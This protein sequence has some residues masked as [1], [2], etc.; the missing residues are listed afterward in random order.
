MKVLYFLEPEIERGNPLFRFGTVRNHL[1]FEIP[2][3]AAHPDVD[4][5]LVCS[6]AVHK[7]IVDAGFLA[8]M[9]I[10]G[11]SEAEVREIHR[12]YLAAS[13][14][15]YNDRPSARA[16]DKAIELYRRR[17]GGFV[18]D[19]VI[20]YES[21]APFFA[22]AF[23][24][25]RV[26]HD[27]LGIFS[28]A[29]YPET[30]CL[31]PAGIGKDSFLRRHAERI[32]AT[33]LDPQQAGRL[34]ELES[35]YRKVLLD[36]SPLTRAHVRQHWSHVVLLPLQVSN[37][38]M[39]DEN[40]E[41]D[42]RL[43]SQRA[44]LEYV[45]ERVDPDVGV[46]TTLHGADADWLTPETAAEIRARFPNFVF[47]PQLQRVPWASQHCLP[48][49]DGVITVSSSVGLQ[50]MLWDLPVGV[51]GRSHVAAVRDASSVEGLVALCRAGARPNKRG[52]LHYLLT[53]YYP[54]LERY[55]HDSR[56]FHAFL[57]RARAAEDPTSFDVMAPIADEGEVF[58]ALRGATRVK[59]Y[60]RD[61]SKASAD[62]RPQE[63]PSSILAD[64]ERHD[65][66]SFDVFDTLITRPVA[67][68][69][70]VLELVEA[71]LARRVADPA[72]L[73]SLATVGGYKRLRAEAG[74]R[75]MQQAQA[76]LRE[77]FGVA[78]LLREMAELAQISLEQASQLF[79]HELEV[80]RR[81]VMPRDEG[82]RLLRAARAARKRVILVSD[83]YF[84]RSFL[85]E[86][87]GRAGVTGF[88]ELY[89]S[90]DLGLL[91][92]TGS[93]FRKIREIEGD[94]R[95][96]H[97]GDNRVSD[98]QM[99][100]REGWT[101]RHLPAVFTRYSTSP[102]VK[103]AWD[104]TD[105]RRGLSSSVLHGLLASRYGDSP[106]R[107]GSDFDGDPV[108]LG[109]EAAGPMFLAFAMWVLRE[110]A[111]RGDEDVFFLAR[112]GF[113]VKQIYDRLLAAGI[114]GPRSHYLLAS[115]RSL[116]TASLGSRADL[117]ASLRLRFSETSL[118]AFFADRFGLDVDALDRRWL[119]TAGFSSWDDPV[120]DRA[121]DAPRLARL[122][123]A[124]SD[125]ILDR[126]RAER[127]AML[128]YLDDEGFH[129]ATRKSVVDIGHN[130]SL[131][132]ALGELTGARDL[133]GFYFAT[134]EGARE[135][136]DAGYD[137]DSYLIRF[138]D[139]RS[140][141]HVYC[142]SIGFFEFLFLP[143]LPSFR[144][145]DLVN[146]VPKPVFVEGDES[147]RAALVRE[148]HRGVLE[149][150]DLAIR[151][152]GE[153]LVDVTFSPGD[154]T[155]RALRFAE[156][157]SRRDAEMFVG[158]S[159]VD[160]FGGNR[161]RFLV[162]PASLKTDEKAFVEASWWRAGGRA[163]VQHTKASD[164]SGTPT[165][166]RWADLLA[167]VTKSR[168]SVA[169]KAR[170]LARDP[171]QFFRDARGLRHGVRVVD[172]IDASLGSDRMARKVRKLLRDP[173]LFVRDARAVRA[174]MSVVHAVEDA[175][176]SDRVSRK[177]RKLRRDPE[178][179]VR[180]MKVWKIFRPG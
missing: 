42:V 101:G 94:R 171:V 121:N 16:D 3:I 53:H 68:H 95:F 2:S 155:R 134:F 102:P 112:D 72:L 30:S 166:E 24:G 132:R 65:V 133:G 125:A 163:V 39:F 47:D 169:R 137:V 41:S 56:W 5:R 129:R 81:L 22:R 160:A 162:A 123:D 82:V 6:E 106:P 31:D 21:N 98:E 99:S 117:H 142:R 126:S 44:F 18:P 59:L 4:V 67:H 50:A 115:R 148:V 15:W 17:L 144:S 119:E 118:R 38:F 164:T 74:A 64:I 63:K 40:V 85:R 86:L 29:P 151:A 1:R 150:C 61:L 69:G 170:K 27:T 78:G 124:C 96:L 174:G 26:I 114:R 173:A 128:R 8:G 35:H 146:G 161:E 130:A 87:L 139:N 70:A 91:K 100:T 36:H 89:V 66:I 9:P 113:L 172:A 105:L 157:P 7:A 11:I 147:V 135:V 57:S 97:I 14:A 51:L 131:Q 62:R 52:A 71:R 20:C 127:T 143:D 145:F 108:R 12:D 107:D 88:D 141:D 23:P 34:S 179:F 116:S 48:H 79:E 28:R 104:R 177:L 165:T 122:L 33:R 93:L 80:E 10:V 19:L 92:K 111:R 158:V 76:D 159:F 138:E 73:E 136:R 153:D 120:S 32:L 75:A 109:F 58:D 13:N 90:S 167:R 46:L 43:P 178:R 84:D 110:S 54:L 83:T 45:L 152:F 25:C 49:V 149:F 180:D 176:T 154:A 175:V 103:R 168:P 156:R 60:L 55:H 140:S 77:E 37:Y